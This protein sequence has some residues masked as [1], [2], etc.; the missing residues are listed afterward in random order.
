MGEAYQ[1]ELRDREKLLFQLQSYAASGDSEVH[2]LVIRNY[3]ALWL[4]VS[5]LSGEGPNAV[6][7]FFAMGMLMTVAAAIGVPELAAQG[8]S[9]AIDVLS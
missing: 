1:R 9:W 6:K 4:E 3:R 5:E 8:D 7:A 2:D